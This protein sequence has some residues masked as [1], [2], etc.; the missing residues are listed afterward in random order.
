MGLS[1]IEDDIFLLN[2]EIEGFE[3]SAME[4]LDKFEAEL[5]HFIEDFKPKKDEA[6]SDIYDI[7]TLNAMEYVASL[8]YLTRYR[9]YYNVEELNVESRAGLDWDNT[10]YQI[11]TEGTQV[12]VGDSYAVRGMVTVNLSPRYYDA[13]ETNDGKVYRTKPLS[14]K[15]K[16]F[17][18][19][20]S[21]G[22]EL[23]VLD[24]VT[25]PLGGEKVMYSCGRANVSLLEENTE[26]N[27]DLWK[28]KNSFTE[29][30]HYEFRFNSTPFT[31]VDV[32]STTGFA[33]F[34]FFVDM[35][36]FR[37]NQDE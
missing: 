12:N 32:D 27:F 33:R 31:P 6:I 34:D 30:Y 35:T 15:S 20:Y 5:D 25:S 37:S 2:K 9:E 11:W 13:M 3:I 10:I 4:A 29:E 23:L 24:E 36:F 8:H 14:F 28:Q 18:G 21:F 22:E 17:V 16:Y 19:P 1:L 7:S 26:H